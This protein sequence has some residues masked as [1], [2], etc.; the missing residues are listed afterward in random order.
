MQTL[1]LWCEYSYFHCRLAA[2]FT[3]GVQYMATTKCPQISHLAGS[4]MENVHG[5]GKGL[6]PQAHSQR[7]KRLKQQT[8]YFLSR[9]ES[10]PIQEKS[11]DTTLT[12]TS[13][14][15]TEH[16][17][18][19]SELSELTP[20]LCLELSPSNTRSSKT[21]RSYAWRSSSVKRQTWTASSFYQ[22]E[23]KSVLPPHSVV[24]RR[25]SSLE[26]PSND[27]LL[28]TW[29]TTVKPAVEQSSQTSVWFAKTL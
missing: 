11:L 29:A 27:E 5:T 25:T 17:Q 22:T 15:L 24:R 4:A 10:F 1:H 20:K 23:P 14:V 21:N 19:S 9:S 28:V 13:N 2:T 12:T 18:A 26:T 3:T 6:S 16:P 8:H 7:E